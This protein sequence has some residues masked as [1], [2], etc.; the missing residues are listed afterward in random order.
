MA[1]K[2]RVGELQK[3]IERLSV[4]WQDV[5]RCRLRGQTMREIAERLGMPLGTVKSR[6]NRAVRAL[7]EA[8]A[9][10]N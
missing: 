5:I 6:L 9:D 8:N 2:I 10:K 1:E 4:P 7:Q 3:V